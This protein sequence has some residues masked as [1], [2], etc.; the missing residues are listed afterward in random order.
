MEPTDA[1]AAEIR[2]LNDRLRVEGKGNGTVLVTLGV[3]ALGEVAVAEIVAAVRRFNDFS[4]ENDPWGEHDFG[5][6]TVDG[7]AIFFKI[8]C[9]DPSCAVGS[10]NPADET[11]TH[12]ILTIMLAAEY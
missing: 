4:S 9:Y 2:R 10:E 12:R 1:H 7:E 5:A 6:L 3:Q 8:D 11:V